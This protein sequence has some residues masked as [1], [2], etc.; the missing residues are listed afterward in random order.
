MEELKNDEVKV[1][2]GTPDSVFSR[3]IFRGVLSNYP[4][5]I[6]VHPDA[7]LSTIYNALSPK[8]AATVEEQLRAAS[9]DRR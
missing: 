3:G 8:M 4:M 5:V 6:T 2:I 7:D 9:T 1:I